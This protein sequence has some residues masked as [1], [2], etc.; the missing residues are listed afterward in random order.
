MSFQILI[1]LNF[2]I[3][4]SLYASRTA[5]QY[6]EMFKDD[7]IHHAIHIEIYAR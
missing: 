2:N 6:N 3:T 5:L 1:S 7:N 4:S